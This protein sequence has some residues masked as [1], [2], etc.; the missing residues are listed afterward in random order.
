LKTVRYEPEQYWEE[1]VSRDFSL[2]GIGFHGLG[3][4]YNKWL[5]KARMRALS[6]LLRGRGIDPCGKRILDIGVGTGFYVDYWKKLDAG[7]VVGLDIT[8]KSVLE[9]EKK[10]PEYK[11]VKADI[12]AIRL[13]VLDEKFD[14]ITAFDVLFHIVGE[15]EFEQALKNIRQ[16]SHRGTQILVFD[17]FLKEPRSPAFHE[18]DRTMDRYKQALDKAGLRPVA[19]IPVFYF[20]SN[21]IDR[22]RLNSRLARVLVSRIWAIVSRLPLL[23]KGLGPLG[24]AI[25]YMIGLIL[26]TVDGIVLKHTEVG[27]HTK[28]ML[29][30]VK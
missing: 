26:Y 16:L 19:I 1:R 12:S 11:F 20:M 8:Q 29:V 4:Q 15:G 17:S 5:Y 22:S 13:D 14:I 6:K 3:S 2:R 28:L 30:Q 10:Y 24:E 27:P 7:S 25:G 23:G 21:P 9:L 18:N